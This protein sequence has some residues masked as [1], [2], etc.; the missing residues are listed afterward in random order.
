VQKG[1]EKGTYGCCVVAPLILCRLVFFESTR[2]EQE[3][4]VNRKKGGDEGGK[5]WNT[6][7]VSILCRSLKEVLFEHEA[8]SP[9]KN[10]A[11]LGRVGL[12]SAECAVDPG[13]CQKFALFQTSSEFF[14]VEFE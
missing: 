10:G 14:C 7:V 4:N 13:P 11:E 1:D 3:G 5:D 9:V 6:W 12:R 2:R 8:L